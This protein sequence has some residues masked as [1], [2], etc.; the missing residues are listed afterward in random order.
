MKY[1]KDILQEAVTNSQSIAGVLRYIGITPSGGMSTYIR[2][3]V[4]AFGID[5]A[6][7]IG[8]G[9]NKGKVSNK[10]RPIEDVLVLLP[11]G[12]S[13]TKTIQLR[14][15]LIDSG[16]L[17][18]CFECGII[19]EWN[20]KKLQFDIDHIDGNHLDNRIDNLRF[21]CPNCHSQQVVTNKPWKNG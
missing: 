5:T 12:S 8:K 21:L 18:V 16:V 1:T 13:R 10:R 11:S 17:H 4:D 20:G 3:R 2:S 7:F 19:D 6:H 9:H 15:A 14:R